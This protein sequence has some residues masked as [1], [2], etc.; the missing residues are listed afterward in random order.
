M[1]GKNV[2]EKAKIIDF[3]GVIPSDHSFFVGAG[4][5]FELRTVTVERTAKFLKCS[6][7]RVRFLL[8]NDRLFG[9]KDEIKGPWKV[10][11]PLQLKAGTR[12]PDIR[13]LPTRLPKE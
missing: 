7:R 12:G 6:T 10:V 8:S 5:R 11:W 3:G 1:K 13:L 9:H 4:S 2:S